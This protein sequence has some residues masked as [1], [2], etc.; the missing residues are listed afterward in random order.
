M[1]GIHHLFRRTSRVISGGYVPVW[2]YQFML[3][4]EYLFTLC[5][6]L[7]VRLQE[8]Y[9]ILAEFTFLGTSRIAV[10]RVGSYRF[11]RISNYTVS[12]K[13]SR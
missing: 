12:G 13:K 5:N 9:V 8:N 11:S 6:S 3:D 2:E 1:Y 10:A 7:T 4:S